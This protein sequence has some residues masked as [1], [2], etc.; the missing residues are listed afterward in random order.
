[1]HHCE[2]HLENELFLFLLSVTV[3]VDPS[4]KGSEE[5][6]PDGGLGPDL[7]A[8]V[9]TTYSEQSSSSAGSSSSSSEQPIYFRCVD[10]DARQT[11]LMTEGVDSIRADWIFLLSVIFREFRFT[12]EV[13]IWLDYHGKHVVIE[14]VRGHENSSETETQFV[15]R[16][17]N[18]RRL[19]SMVFCFS[20]D[21]CRDSD[22]SGSAE[23]LWAETEAALLQTRV[24]TIN[25]QTS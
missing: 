19:Y 16:H 21:V 22:R 4:Q 18:Y 6:G 10:G 23:L 15:H 20:G 13:P 1:M 17:G 11:E 25:I 7:T 12:S 8:S 14:Q 9:E 5:A 24:K 3:K 2:A